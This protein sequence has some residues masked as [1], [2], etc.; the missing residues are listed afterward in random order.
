MRKHK[1][2]SHCF[3]KMRIAS[4]CILIML[5][6]FLLFAPFVYAKTQSKTS[7]SH[8][9][10]GLLHERWNEQ[11]QAIEEYRQAEEYDYYS[12]QIHLK[13]GAEYLRN[14]DFLNA[15]H[16]LELAAK[17]EPENIQSR[18]V[19]GLLYSALGRQEEASIQYEQV[20]KEASKKDPQ[21]LRL[22]HNLAEFYF[23]QNKL[24]EALTQYEH[25]LSIDANDKMA[26]YYLGSIFYVQEKKELAIEEFKKAIEIDPIYADALN[27][28]GYAYAEEGTNLDEAVDLIK[29]ALSVDPDNGAYLDSLGWVYFKKGL[30]QQALEQIER[31]AKLLPD[32]EIYSHL[33]D[34]YYK[35]DMFE[36][37]EESWR[38]SL[39][40]DPFNEEVKDKLEN[41]KKQ[42]ADEPE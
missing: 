28:L 17:L 36:K 18:F 13:L 16:H 39:E 35:L 26:R 2:Q 1:Q 10:M 23:R 32:P 27:S 11:D 30:N 29:R 14:K 7:L 20:L 8:Y 4:L 5:V 21:N 6:S 42:K 33:G 40:I 9:L 37:A 25:I 31:A 15:L 38:G 19:L 41:L 12:A 24:D 3:L 34:V 22:Y